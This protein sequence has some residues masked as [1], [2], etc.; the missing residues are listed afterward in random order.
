[1]SD[2]I[3][4][5]GL[6]PKMRP[7]SP[8]RSTLVAALDVGTSK[9]VCM[10]ARLKPIGGNQVLRQRSHTVE[11]LGLGH[12]RSRGMKSGAVVDLA[13]CEDAI[14]HAVDAA[15]R[16]A[17]VQLE[18]VVLSL[19]SGRLGSDRYRAEVTMPRPAV[20]EGDIHRVLLAGNRHCV[21]DGRVVLHSLPI[22]YAL[23]GVSGVRDP[24]GLLGRRLGVDMHMASAD[25]GPARNLM[26]AVERGHLAVEAMV[27]SP[28]ASSLS[29]LSDDEPDL[30][31]A[32]V[33]MGAGTT[34]I[35]IYSEGHLAHVDAVAVGGLH[36]TMD[37][38][39]G[40]S[41]PV[42]D[43]ERIKTLHAAAI[44][45][46]SDERDMI[47]V[48]SAGED[49]REPA[50]MVPR[51]TILKITRPRLEET[52]ELVRDRIA[53][54]GLGNGAG[55]RIVLTGGA[56]QLTGLQDLAARILGRQVRIG[57]PLG[58]SGL[59]DAAKGPAFAA[60][61]GLLIYPQA[62]HL[63]HFEGRTNG[64][65]AATGTDGYMSQV[66]RWIRESF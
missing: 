63:E 6:T 39:R 8:R 33:D 61:A 32:V 41:T 22:G 51:A 64:A 23:D 16:M 47:A 53:A 11:V 9:V 5:N 36:V 14:R 24:R 66:G 62:A 65:A 43:A 13:E 7:I 40:L 46:P 29:V 50:N 20:D 38:A 18:S 1:M 19:S 10:I 44:G 25:T 26:L 2:T 4:R 17:G 58:L 59:P 21:R 37:L 27:A 34:S 15:E 28:Y 48:P 30:G 49:E 55:S 56:S 54:S 42:A 12:T 57:R 60:A 52:L 31:V 3:F 45:V 35:A